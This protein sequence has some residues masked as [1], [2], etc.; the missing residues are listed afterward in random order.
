MIAPRRFLPSISSLLALEAVERLGTA[1]AAAEEL[2]LTHSAVS[3]QLRVLEEQIGVRLF[4]RSGKSLRLTPAGMAYARSVRDLLNDLARASLK[5]RAS[6][7]RAS[8][9]LAVLPS[10]GMY[11]LSPRLRGFRQ[12]HPDILVNQS[13]R[14][15]PFDFE[16]EDF[17]AA[18]HFGAQDWRGVQYLP[19]LKERVIAVC[20]PGFADEIPMPPQVLTGQ[21]L[22]HLESRPGAWE[23]WFKAH[24]HDADRLRGMLF[25][26]FTNMAEAA[27]SGAGV[28]LLPE[29]LARREF[30]RGR[31][32]PA[33]SGYVDVEGTYYLVWPTNGPASAALSSFLVWLSGAGDLAA[34]V[35]EL[36]A[37]ADQGQFDPRRNV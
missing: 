9:N 12:A 13:T 11:W 19:L 26:Q 23:D 36:R 16:R 5:V 6:G 1:T 24:G 31:L 37:D 27:V 34:G 20:A 30:R 25:D 7:S 32:V 3:R 35:G 4:I 8:L 14:I 33:S 18:I 21:P 10:F 22:L 17:D 15:R 28:A 29:F 2:S